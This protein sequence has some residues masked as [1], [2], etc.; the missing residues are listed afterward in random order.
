MTWVCGQFLIERGDYLFVSKVFIGSHHKI[1]RQN[2]CHDEISRQS[3]YFSVIR[4]NIWT[5]KIYVAIPLLCPNFMLFLFHCWLFLGCGSDLDRKMY[6]P[7]HDKTN[8]MACV[9]SEDSDQP[10]HPAQ[11]DQSL[12][13][14]HEKH[15]VLSCPMSLI[16]LGGW[17]GWSESSLG[18]HVILLVLSCGGSYVVMRFCGLLLSVLSS[19]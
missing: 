7:A 18:A 12:P 4:Y 19:I 14:Q 13:C 2:Q 5:W 1:L 3:E 8:K 11:S 15:W 16:R 17:P 9:S 10:G 6:E